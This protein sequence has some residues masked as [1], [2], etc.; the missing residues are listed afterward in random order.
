MHLDL[1]PF[2]GRLLDGQFDYFHIITFFGLIL[3]PPVDKTS[4]PLYMDFI[5]I[6]GPITMVLSSCAAMKIRVTNHMRDT[7]LSF[8]FCLE[9]STL[10]FTNLERVSIKIRTLA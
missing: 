8:E 10:L 7:S 4:M 2:F 1:V 9:L 5:P 3:V 6:N